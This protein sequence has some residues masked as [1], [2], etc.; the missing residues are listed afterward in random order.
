MPEIVVFAQIQ[1]TTAGNLTIDDKTNAA[2]PYSL[3]R[4][5]IGPG[6]STMRKVVVESPFVQGRY[7]VHQVRGSGTVIL[8]IRIRGASFDWLDFYTAQLLG[9][10]ENDFHLSI[11]IDGTEHNWFFEAVDSWDVGDPQASNLGNWEDVALR[12]Y[13][14]VLTAH[15]MRQPGNVAGRF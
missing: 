8:Q 3:V 15:T 4:N 5:G 14:Q 11:T 6:S 7:V 1:T 12:S 2:V 9:F 13:T 10:L